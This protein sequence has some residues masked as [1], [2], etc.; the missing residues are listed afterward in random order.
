[1]NARSRKDGTVHAVD[2]VKDGPHRV[3]Q[4]DGEIVTVEGSAYWLEC[5]LWARESAVELV[6]D[7]VAPTCMACL[8]KERINER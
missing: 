3:K 5:G 6:E 1:M 8:A 7:S 2:H 4:R